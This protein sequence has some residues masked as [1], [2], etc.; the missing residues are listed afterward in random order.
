VLHASE[1]DPL[2]DT[3]HSAE[4]FSTVPPILTSNATVMCA[5]GGRVTLIPRQFKVLVQGAPVMCVPDLIGA[6][7]A[8]CAQPPT[9][10]T[11]PCTTVVS[12]LPG[13]WSLKVLVGG[14]PAY[15]A[16]LSGLTDGVPPSPIIVVFPGQT[17]V[18]G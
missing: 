15:V 14:K 10:A 12:T 6:P 18:Q 5:H 13:S 11:K 3:S 1:S 2:S 8:G 4:P 9:P 16:T 7:I 17:T